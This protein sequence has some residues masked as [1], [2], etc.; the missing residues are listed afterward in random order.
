MRAAREASLPLLVIGIAGLSLAACGSA[1]ADSNLDGFAETIGFSADTAVSDSGPSFSADS[2]MA[3]APA[4]KDCPGGAGCPCSSPEE[5]DGGLC[6]ETAAGKRCA[7]KCS[8]T[9]PTGYRCA[10]V[11]LGAD[12]GVACVADDARLCSPC[13]ANSE[14]R[15]AGVDDARCVAVGAAGSFC[16]MGCSESVACH[17]GY[18]CKHVVDVEGNKTRQCLP[19]A[20][21]SGE[22]GSCA[23]SPNARALG[24][25][26]DCS[27]QL[28]ADGKTFQCAGTRTCNES[29]LT[30]CQAADPGPETCDGV[31][32]DCDGG[33]DDGACDDNNACTKD[34]C[35]PSKAETDPGAA[36]SHTN[37][38]AACDADGSACTPD[39][40][41]KDGACVVGPA[42]VCD[43]SNPCT[44]DTCNKEKGC[45]FTHNNAG[46]DDD[47]ACT[48]GDICKA[49]GCVGGAPKACTS[50]DPCEV[51]KCDQATGKCTFS[52]KPA[53]APC[54]DGDACTDKDACKSGLCFGV[55][56]ACDDA[57]S[58]TTDSC[59]AATGCQFKTKVGA[60]DD[61]DQCTQGDACSGG[62]CK[63]TLVDGS[64]LCDDSNPCTVD[65]CAHLVGCSHSP[66]SGAC[67]D[68]SQ[69]TKD[70]HC[71]GGNCQ[72][73]QSCSV[74]KADSD[75]PNNGNPCA[76]QLFCDKGQTPAVCVLNPAAVVKCSTA[77]NTTC[78]KNQCDGKT[79]ACTGLKAVN[80]GKTCDD[81]DPCSLGDSCTNGV[82]KATGKKSCD[83]GNPCTADVCA[84]KAGCA[85]TAQAGACSD[86]DPCTLNDSCVQGAC[87][88]GAVNDCDD[89]NV[90]TADSCA[91][92]KGCIHA[93]QSGGCDDNNSCTNNDVCGDGKCQ[94]QGAKQCDD[95]NP[96]TD[97]GC[98]AT[99]GCVFSPNAKPCTDNN[100]CT[101]NDY[102]SGGGCKSGT[103][104]SCSHLDSACH[105]GICSGGICTSNTKSGSCSDGN[106]CTENDY[107]S[108]GSCK[109]GSPKNCSAHAN[110]CRTAACSGGSCKTTNL[111]KGT[112]CSKGQ[113][114]GSGS[115]EYVDPCGS[116]A[117]D[118]VDGCT[119]SYYTAAC[120]SNCEGC[121][122]QNGFTAYNMSGCSG[123]TCFQ[124]FPNHGK[125]GFIAMFRRSSQT[126]Y[127]RWD[128]DKTLCGNW[129]I[130]VYLPNPQS[131]GLS[132]TPCSSWKYVTDARYNLKKGNTTVS[133]S[134]QINHSSQK[135]DYVQIFA[136]K[137]DGVT[138]VT[139]GNASSTSGC[140][141]FL[142]DELK[143]VPY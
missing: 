37:I 21:G 66:K 114:N 128:F 45:R 76:G 124:R 96:C 87:K 13:Q 48:V 43:D 101:L 73:T 86:S 56:A 99:G 81:S 138:A 121:K 24:F 108:S 107:C 16:G 1:P 39:D 27:N 118:Y 100:P 120:K 104:K 5:C 116:R 40:V 143:A 62:F 4:A 115:C 22:S 23:C 18:S 51:T 63:G 53:G 30:P 123:F 135:G 127:I 64:A 77:G 142:V 93:P 7:Q 6:L 94:G 126:A 44:D 112:K 80:D 3:D 82:C 141:Y 68:G 137:M 125:N 106:S 79:G 83:D 78:L 35:D 49:G 46:C 2:N 36:C 26:T 67:D 41:C 14:C 105:Y 84:G 34:A 25:K 69:C 8:T 75:C 140:T 19:V 111:S 71:S 88:P 11:P 15:Y 55:A 42:K 20:D 98:S 61:G 92:L 50:T 10:T 9:C 131:Y 74:C 72:G 109:S 103:P 129:R 102:C 97:D 119:G 95:A 139:L 117:T 90:C 133:T 29:G 59:V 12:V 65:A 132:A 31:D 28:T 60:C 130:Y 89:K 57:N 58:C 52:P 91:P 113:C 17:D 32:N 136:G 47:N 122:K 85:S 110:E 70:D 38:D 54:D 33:T 134:A